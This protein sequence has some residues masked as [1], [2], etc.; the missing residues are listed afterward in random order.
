M[1]IRK[2]WH[3][4]LNIALSG[5]TILGYQV[6][7]TKFDTGHILIINYQRNSREPS[8][9]NQIL[10][11][12]SHM[13]LPVF[14]EEALPT[15]LMSYNIQSSYAVMIDFRTK[16]GI[17]M[18]QPTQFFSLDEI[19]FNT[20]P[21][22]LPTPR[23]PISDL[24][25][26][27]EFCSSHVGIDVVRYKGELFAFKHHGRYP[28]LEEGA[29]TWD[30]ML[31]KEILHL[32]KFDSPFISP[33]SYVITG[34]GKSASNFRGFLQPFATAGSLHDVLKSLDINLRT[35]AASVETQKSTWS[36][37]WSKYLPTMSTEI[38]PDSLL[39][40]WPVK[41]KWAIDMTSGLVVLHR[42]GAFVGLL[43]LENF[44][45]NRDGH[46]SMIDISPDMGFFSC[47]AAPEV[48][49]GLNV[50]LTGPRD[51]FSLGLI[52]WMLAEEKTAHPKR[53]TTW[54]VPRPTWHDGPNSAPRWFRSLVQNCLHADPAQ[55]PFA[56]IVLSTLT[57]HVS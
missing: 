56:N 13:P 6:D 39:V 50:A 12:E 53:D 14:H 15:L 3:E 51:I 29:S 20:I 16:D 5:S 57:A 17:R 35:Q 2:E 34:T 47:F 44:L 1:R 4:S 31:F 23:V 54:I 7:R 24:V 49:D 46:V 40:T 36:L 11:T 32:A 42:A 18:Y 30:D 19:P 25:A 45:L 33:A 21:D 43:S 10:N 22:T 37:S 38:T 9:E 28:M 55:R 26:P 48:D 27:E 8:L 52:L 41:H